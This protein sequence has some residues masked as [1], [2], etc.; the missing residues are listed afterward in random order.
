MFVV[1]A[2]TLFWSTGRGDEQI[3]GLSRGTVDSEIFARILFS[4]ILVKYILVM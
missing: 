2:L 4:Q 3:Q 1:I